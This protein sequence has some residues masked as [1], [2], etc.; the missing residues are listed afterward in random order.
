M[1][2]SHATGDRPSR[3]TDESEG[4]EPGGELIARSRHG[5]I[6]ACATGIV[7]GDI[8]ERYLIRGGVMG[9]QR[10]VDRNRRGDLLLGDRP[11]A[12]KGGH[13]SAHHDARRAM[14]N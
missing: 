11:Q 1:A 5:G 9:G 3:R 7:W 14:K 8:T 6:P 4:Q 13:G 10:P 2:A 12:G